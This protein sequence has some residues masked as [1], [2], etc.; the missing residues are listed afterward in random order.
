[1]SADQEPETDELLNDFF[2]EADQQLAVLEKN[3]LLL[4]QTPACREYLDEIFRAAH[5]LKSAAATVKMTEIETLTHLLEDLLAAVRRSCL[6]VNR[7]LIDALLQAVDTTRV[8][9][10]KRAGGGIYGGDSEAFAARLRSLLAEPVVSSRSAAGDIPSRV[11]AAPDNPRGENPL[12]RLQVDFSADNPMK[13]VGGVQVYTLL[14]QIGRVVATRPDLEA[15]CGDTFF[16]RV[17]YSVETDRPDCELIDLCT[18]PDVTLGCQVLPAQAAPRPGADAA[19]AAGEKPAGEEREQAGGGERAYQPPLRVDSRRIDDLLNL[20]NEAMVVKASLNRLSAQFEDTLRSLHSAEAQYRQALRQFNRS[21]PG[22]LE[23]Y[24][25]GGPAG[26]L[27]EQI[28]MQFD[29]IVD[30]FHSFQETLGER[31]SR[32]R[33]TTMGLGRIT[34]ELQKSILRVRM[35]PLTQLFSRFP[36]L[37]RDLTRSVEKQIELVISGADTELDRSLIADIQDPLVHCVR[38]AIDHG[39]ETP[40]ERVRSGKEAQGRIELAARADSRE[41]V[42]TVA[43]DGRGIDL[44]RVKAKARERGLIG[45][46]TNPGREELLEI[47]FTPGF[48][49]ADAVTRISGRGVGLDVIRR[50]VEH[51]GGTVKL[52]SEAGKGTR[53]T[54]RLPLRLAVVRSLLVRAGE[55]ICAIP[56]VSVVESLT[57]QKTEMIPAGG[58][59]SALFFRGEKIPLLLPS[60]P[61]KV[62]GPEDR[63]YNYKY[64]VVLNEGAKRAGL[65]VDSLLDEEEIVVKPPDHLQTS[66]AGT[67]GSALLA[68]GSVARVLDINQLLDRAGPPE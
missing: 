1:M 42:I 18:I 10:E 66:V 57:L 4:E 24:R 11:A 31:S 65:V 47:I 59:G 32:F 55:E 38:N 37:V 17:V 62:D 8:M 33:N 67:A 45:P 36:R 61:F 54:L 22:Y 60:F 53:F 50:Q 58:G 6:E 15:L 46:D 52:W 14:K 12:V 51:L 21:L 28:R 13:T 63:A 49:T 40:G 35:A 64:V 23:K 9:V 20:A 68:D 3:V 48:S 25:Q 56:A 16:D 5:S 41:V 19:E 34:E 26:P 39:I 29:R 43:D 30:G 2:A 7:G 44:M 27:R